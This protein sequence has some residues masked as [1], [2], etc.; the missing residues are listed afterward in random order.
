[1][2]LGVEPEFLELAFDHLALLVGV[3]DDKATGQTGGL[4]VA[5]EDLQRPAVEGADKAPA[6]G[7]AEQGLDP[8]AHLEGRLVG[9]GHGGDLGVAGPVVGQEVGDAVGQNPG[10]ARARAGEDQQRSGAVGDRFALRIV[11]VIGESAHGRALWH[12]RFSAAAFQ[13]KAENR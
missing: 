4:R 6:K 10:L 11:E 1:M 2:F 3:G 8:F 9:E 12:S 5:A 7:L 13:A